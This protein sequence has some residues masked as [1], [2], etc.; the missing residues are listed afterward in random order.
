[1]ANDEKLQ[2]DIDAVKTLL[3]QINEIP[4]EMLSCADTYRVLDEY[5]DRLAS[6]EPVER[7]M[8]AVKYHLEI[9]FPCGQEFEILRKA[10]AATLE[11]EDA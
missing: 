5:V 2:L 1:M 11:D 7:F 9:C 4:S 6:G 10:L 8:P 3:Q